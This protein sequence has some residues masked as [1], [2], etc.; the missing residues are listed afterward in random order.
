MKI[1]K[2]THFKEKKIPQKIFFNFKTFLDH[3]ILFYISIS[4]ETFHL[5]FK[6]F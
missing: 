3:I 2:E 4:L 1:W 5:P 6:M